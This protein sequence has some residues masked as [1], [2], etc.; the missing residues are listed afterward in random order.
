M[1]S[2]TVKL[3]ISNIF[4]ELDV[5]FVDDATYKKLENMG[6]QYE[7]IDNDLLEQMIEV[8]LIIMLD[9]GK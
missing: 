7:Y 8:E 5:S 9:R 3:T 4:K 2:D 6:S 1:G